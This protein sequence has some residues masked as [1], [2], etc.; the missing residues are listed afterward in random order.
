MYAS[1]HSQRVHSTIPDQEKSFCSTAYAK[2]HFILFVTFLVTVI[3]P[4]RNTGPI[5]YFF[6]L[7]G[8]SLNTRFGM[9]ILFCL[10]VLVCNPRRAFGLRHLIYKTACS[11]RHI[12]YKLACSSHFIAA[13]SCISGWP[14]AQNSDNAIIKKQDYEFRWRDQFRLGLDPE[15]G[16]DAFTN[17]GHLPADRSKTG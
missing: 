5:H 10:I 15:K 3:M 9:A 17:E 12:T 14:G 1:I 2:L 6:R 4:R 16:G 11:H 7:Y 8:A 13:E